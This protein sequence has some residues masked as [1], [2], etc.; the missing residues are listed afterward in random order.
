MFSVQAAPGEGHSEQE[1]IRSS[2]KSRI[3]DSISRV[4]VLLGRGKRNQNWPGNEVFR[5]Y[6]SIRSK[7]YTAPNTSKTLRDDIAKEVIDK[8]H[9]S[10]GRFLQ[11]AG[12]KDKS[13]TDL[14]TSQGLTDQTWALANHSTIRTKTKQALRDLQ[15]KNRDPSR[16]VGDGH[17]DSSSGSDGT[18]S[19]LMGRNILPTNQP[20]RSSTTN[21]TILQE[22]AGLQAAQPFG[23]SQQP[24][25]YGMTLP[26]L[27]PTMLSTL[28]PLSQDNFGLLRD[29]QDLQGQL[30]S[31]SNNRDMRH[32]LS[33][34][35]KIY[36]DNWLPYATSKMP[37]PIYSPA[38]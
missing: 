9:K 29:A 16:P 4:D 20:S 5:Q 31:M 22:L 21:A 38:C 33:M 1:P 14:A 35:H 6:V 15:K 10:G 36:K 30:G 19:G 25:N 13:S 24:M 28:M 8:V 26:Q 12:G 11:E 2:R 7:E 32:L 17:R 37:C 18:S 3:V 27:N 34:P 23:F